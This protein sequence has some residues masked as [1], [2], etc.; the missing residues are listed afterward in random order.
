MDSTIYTG[1]ETTGLHS[2]DGKSI[3]NTQIPTRTNSEC[4]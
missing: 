1:P 2:N 4:K 3:Q